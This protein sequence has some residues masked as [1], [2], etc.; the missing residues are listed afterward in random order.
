MNPTFL[1]SFFIFD[2]ILTSAFIK[3]STQIANQFNLSSL[4]ELFEAIEYGIIK[5]EEIKPFY[6]MC[7]VIKT[8]K[9]YFKVE[10]TILPALREKYKISKVDADKNN[11]NLII[12]G[13]KFFAEDLDVLDSQSVG[14]IYYL[15]DKAG[16]KTAYARN[17]DENDGQ[18]KKQKLCPKCCQDWKRVT[19]QKSLSQNS[20]PG[21]RT[22]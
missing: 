7:V 16:I 9:E 14:I 13:E 6:N 3:R 5:I 19:C 11:Y 12:N 2:N 21:R 15:L 8:K 1:Q 10:E 22:H 20:R 18:I 17:L 4:F